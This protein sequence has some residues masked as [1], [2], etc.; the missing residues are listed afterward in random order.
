MERESLIL[1]NKRYGNN[2]FFQEFL[3]DELK[4]QL[5]NNNIK[6]EVFTEEGE[7]KWGRI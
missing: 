4:K 1:L 5:N 2:P 7:T 6:V 3:R